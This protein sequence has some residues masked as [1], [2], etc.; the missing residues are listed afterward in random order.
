MR[1]PTMIL[2]RTRKRV[3]ESTRAVTR[4]R[5]SL[6][7]LD[8]ARSSNVFQMPAGGGQRLVRN[9]DEGRLKLIDDSL[10]LAENPDEHAVE[11][12]GCQGGVLIAGTHLPVVL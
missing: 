3:R 10:R 5:G 7:G 4:R 2:P 1:F 8:H 6:W 11:P 9:E 12:F